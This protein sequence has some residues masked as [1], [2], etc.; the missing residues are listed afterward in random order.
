MSYHLLQI[1]R[2]LPLTPK[3]VILS[4]AEA[5]RSAVEGSLA[6]PKTHASEEMREILRLHSGLKADRNSA[7]N[8][9]L[10]G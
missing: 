5:L 10:C 6:S 8:D 9:T 4:G 3:P 1:I 2:L 7:Q